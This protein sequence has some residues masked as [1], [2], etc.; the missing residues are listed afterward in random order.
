MSELV[1]TRASVLNTEPGTEVFRIYML[2]RYGGVN[3]RLSVNITRS[4]CFWTSQHPEHPCFPER[5]TSQGRGTN[6]QCQTRRKTQGSAL[7]IWR[8]SLEFLGKSQDKLGFLSYLQAPHFISFNLVFSGPRTV[9]PLRIRKFT[10]EA[11]EIHY[12]WNTLPRSLSIT[13]SG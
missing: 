12:V 6:G 2:N 7:K 10:G 1:Q 9:D 13:T 5:H 3:R 4:S 8:R 11:Q